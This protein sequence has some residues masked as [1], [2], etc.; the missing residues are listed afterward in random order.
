MHKVLL[1]TRI[2]ITILT[3]TPVR[4]SA[5]ALTHISLASFCGTKA[6]SAGPD[7]TSGSPLFAYRIFNENVNIMENTTQRP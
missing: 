6:D 2:Q 4:T 1:K 7:L 5:W 3:L